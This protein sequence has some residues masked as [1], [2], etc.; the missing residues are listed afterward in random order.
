MI[1]VS[2]C[3][4]GVPCRYDGGSNYCEAAGLRVALGEALCICPECLGGLSIPREPAEI[5]G[6]SA[7]D[8]LA[9]HAR[10]L[11]KSGVDVT[12][13]FV[14]GAYAALEFC[15]IHGIKEAILKAKSPSCGCGMIYDGTFSGHLIAGNGVA[16]ALLR[17]NGIAVRVEYG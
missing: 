17:Q 4:A 3:L 13:A 14:Q 12:E 1:A 10:V 8:V 7:E 5:V 15:K 9:G 16:A 6:G 2:A 11:T